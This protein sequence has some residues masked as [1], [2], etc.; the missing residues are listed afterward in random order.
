MKKMGL[1]KILLGDFFIKLLKIMKLSIF[2]L[3]VSALSVVASESY[4]QVTKLSLS[5]KNESIENVLRRIEDQSEYRFFYSGKIDTDRKVSIERSGTGIQEILNE[6]LDGTGI[7]YRIVGRQVALF[8]KGEEHVSFSATQTKTV[9]GKVTDSKG[10]PLPGVTVVVK[11][12]TSGTIT[13]SDGTYILT[14]VPSNAVLVFSF[15]GM[16]VQEINVE[17]KNS[18]D[19]RLEEETIGIEEVVAIGY[20]TQKKVNLT[21]AVA[22][23]N[24]DVLENRPVANISQALKG[25]VPNL[26]ITTTTRGGELGNDQN[27]NIRG[28][29]SISGGEPYILIDNVPMDVMDINPNDIES[30][31]VLKD[32][33]ASAIYGSRAAY[34]VILITTKK[35]N[36]NERMK[37]NYSSNFSWNSPTLLPHMASSIDFANSWNYACENSG[38]TPLFN[39]EQLALIQQYIDDPVNTPPNQH[40]P[41]NHAKW[42]R[43]G[44]YTLSNANVDWY[45]VWFRNNALHQNHNLSVRGGSEKT[46]YYV[47][48]GYL[49]Q[50]GSLNFGTDTY[51]RYNVNANFESD[52]TDWFKFRFDTKYTRRER[53]Y[54]NTKQESS[55]SKGSIYHN[56]ARMWPTMPVYDPNGHIYDRNQILPLLEGGI[57]D[58][59]NNFWVTL[60]GELEVIKN[61]LV[62]VDYSWNN[63]NYQYTNHKPTIYGYNVD[64][65]TFILTGDPNSIEEQ[66]SSTTYYTVNA[67]TSYERSLKDHYF[68]LMIG[69]QEELQ[70]Y[71]SLTGSR[72]N[73]ITDNVPSISTA[74]SEIPSVD[75]ALSHWATQGFFGRFNYNFKGKYLVEIN[76]RYD[77]SSRFEEGKRWGLFP[78]VSLGYRISEELFWENLKNTIG[79]LK[80][81]GSFGELGNQDVDN[82]LYISTIPVKTNLAYYLNNGRPLYSSAPGLI[83]SDLTWET[84]ST[85]DFGFD[86]GF[87]DNRLN[88]TFDWY[89]RTTKDM[90][91][92]AE[93]LPVVIGASIPKKNNATLETRGFELSLNWRDKIGKDITYG[94]TFTL[95]DYSAEVTKYN[96]PTRILSTYYEGMDFGEI[97]GYTSG[98]LF[99][100]DEEAT[101]WTSQISQSYL[102]GKWSAGDMKY[103]DLNDDNKI[104]IGKNTVDDPGDRSVIGNSTPRYAY[105]LQAD[106]SWKGFDFSMLIQGIAKR[107]LALGGGMF[108]GFVG[109]EWSSSCFRQHLDH[110]T[111][112]HKDAYYPKPYMSSEH[113]KNTKTQTRYLQNGSYLRLRNIQLGYTIPDQLVK[114]IFLD[115]V[116]FYVS[117]ENLLTITDLPKMFDPEG[118]SGDNGDGKIYPI[119]KS[120]SLGMNITF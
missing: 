117:G 10:E 36:K 63:M 6:I 37:L 39:D 42:N 54:P 78:S 33:A 81:R 69:Y 80:I 75:D 15:V 94:L 106:V 76:C 70:K 112:E 3:L 29:T 87:L 52:I 30:V 13:G 66:Y 28:I 32:A 105:G 101:E 50:E 48:G 114:K 119:S 96:N 72:K 27:W 7:D 91:G 89:K 99:R 60:G 116:K 118:I 109:D 79:N 107:D 68:K 53:K 98:G 57:T 67:Y 23:V 35:G 22:T 100:S 108:Y 115:Q 84:S 46:R 102:Y 73:L 20:G 77:G 61:W 41:A 45:P 4:S 43:W 74:T 110:W 26:N 92:P 64:E 8:S 58:N 71:G 88:L 31:S 120:I 9:Q 82:Y 47:S 55:D 11:G 38:R 49:D 90:F 95:S 65:T 2:I 51:Q 17:G 1:K 113:N 59:W 103:L 44:A 5:I 16:R 104:D 24:S 25:V 40:Y 56:I 18:I 86:A 34:G 111:S 93:A 21:G 85:I 19:V 83:S 62:N 14:D 97:W 12:S